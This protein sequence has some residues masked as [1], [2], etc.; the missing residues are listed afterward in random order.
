MRAKARNVT[1]S[2]NK[3]ACVDGTSSPSNEQEMLAARDA[4]R[5]TS[6]RFLP[7]ASNECY[8]TRYEMCGRDLFCTRINW[9][10][11]EW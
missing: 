5:S 2:C 3:F 11:R 8:I 9:L 4:L 1:D 7:V 6:C 10:Q